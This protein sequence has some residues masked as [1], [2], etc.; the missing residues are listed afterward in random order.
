MITLEG[1]GQLRKKR[2]GE[3]NGLLKNKLAAMF[4]TG[5]GQNGGGEL[6]QAKRRGLT[7]L[8]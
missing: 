2:S 4:L 8:R 3:E 1:G 5:N 6:I 7:G